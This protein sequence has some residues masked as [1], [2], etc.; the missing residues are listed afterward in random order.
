VDAQQQQLIAVTPAD[1]MRSG[2][3]RDLILGHL[4]RMRFVGLDDFEYQ[5][6]FLLVYYEFGNFVK[7]YSKF[8]YANVFCF[9]MGF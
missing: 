5:E 7:Y 4:L 8:F 2:V 6:K 9:P 1:T 3:G